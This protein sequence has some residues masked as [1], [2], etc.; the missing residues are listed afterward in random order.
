VCARGPPEAGERAGELMWVMDRAGARLRALATLLGGDLALARV[1]HR[2]DDDHHAPAKRRRN[3]DRDTALAGIAEGLL[4]RRHLDQL[5]DPDAHVVTISLTRVGHGRGRVASDGA[6][7]GTLA[8]MADVLMHGRWLDDDARW[9]DVGAARKRDG[10]VVTFGEAEAREALDLRGCTHVVLVLRDAMIAPALL[11]EH[12]S[13]VFRSLAG[14]PEIVRVEVTRGAA[15]PKAVVLAHA[16]ALAAFDAAVDSGGELP[17]NPERILPVVRTLGWRAPLRAGEAF[18]VDLEDF[19]TGWSTALDV[20]TLDDA[21]RM[22]W[23]LRWS[24]TS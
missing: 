12:G 2:D 13:H 17:P 6:E 16:K 15:D 5:R 11:G 19:S 7:P 3:L 9:F 8:W 10:N 1:R 24:A 22:A 20:S 18:H 23:W 4:L 21:I 14:E